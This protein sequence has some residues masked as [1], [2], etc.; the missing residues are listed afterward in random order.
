VEQDLWPALI[1]YNPRVLTP[2]TDWTG[3]AE[4]REAGLEPAPRPHESWTPLAVK[5]IGLDEAQWWILQAQAGA[6]GV[7]ARRGRQGPEAPVLLASSRPS[8]LGL[9]DDLAATACADLAAALRT[10][11]DAADQVDRHDDV[12]TWIGV[13]H[14]RGP[15]G[16]RPPPRARRLLMGVVNVTP[17]SFSDGGRFLDAE[18]AVAHGLA[19]AEAGADLLDV[20]GESTRPGAAPVDADEELRRVLPVVA[21]LAE[22]GVAPVSIDTS[23]PAVARACVEAGAAMV[24]DVAALGGDPAMAETLAALQVPVCL[25]HMLGSPRTMQQDPHYDDLMG[26]VCLYLRRAMARGMAAG[27]RDDRFLVDP[28]IGF[29]KT[30]RHNL[31]ILN[32]LWQMRSLGR[33]IVVGTS[34]KSFIGKVLGGEKAVRPV[35]KRLMGTAATVALAAMNGAHVLR[36]HDVAEMRDVVQVLDAEG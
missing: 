23:K 1:R 10:T 32:R 18:A 35:E 24:N 15:S 28:G 29:G 7:F 25:M 14:P 6:H 31:T 27:I 34:R 17:D 20:G 3:A 19:L 11:V 16:R 5:C 26:E 21:Q 33:P 4:W 8:L 36:V 12:R 2:P 22:A 9:V 13:R 30:V